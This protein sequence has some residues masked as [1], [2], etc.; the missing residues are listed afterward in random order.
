M[1][2]LHPVKQFR[3]AP[4]V[5]IL[6]FCLSMVGAVGM[7]NAQPDVSCVCQIPVGASGIVESVAGNVF[8]S[9]AMGAVPARPAA[10]LVAGDAV[11]AGPRSSS[12]VAFEGCRLSLGANTTLEA[13]SRGGFLCLT[14]D[15]TQAGVEMTA[16]IGVT[17]AASTLLSGG[18]IVP[19]GIAAGLG[20][21]A[22]A[23]TV[24]QLAIREGE[25]EF[26][27]IGEDRAVS[28]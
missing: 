13:A 24:T 14:D 18:A 7:V 22:V 26:S 23:F 10:R 27:F 8:M 12:V 5:V 6:G 20:L 4:C 2:F 25:V 9:Q 19:V 28:K 16:Q 21:G 3:I 15:E 11:L 1:G 17:A